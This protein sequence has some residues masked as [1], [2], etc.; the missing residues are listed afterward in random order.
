M[1]FRPVDNSA[2]CCHSHWTVSFLPVTVPRE[3]SWMLLQA[4]EDQGSGVCALLYLF[5]LLALVRSACHHTQI[6][7]T[8]LS[9]MVLLAIL[10]F[11]T[12]S[13]IV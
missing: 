11:E 4:E 12:G 2:E 1:L 9:W 6:P 13:P 3:S 8:S 7:S 10:L 5:I